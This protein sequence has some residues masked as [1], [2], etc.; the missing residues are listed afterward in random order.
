MGRNPRGG[1]RRR[2]PAA[3]HR[4]RRGSARVDRADQARGAAERWRTRSGSRSRS[5][6]PTRRRRRVCSTVFAAQG[7]DDGDQRT[8]PG[9][10]KVASKHDPTF[11]RRDRG[12]PARRDHGSEARRSTPRDGKTGNLKGRVKPAAA[13]AQMSGKGPSGVF[14]WNM[15]PLMWLTFSIAGHF[16]SGKRAAGTEGEVEGGP[17]AREEAPQAGDQDGQGGAGPRMPP[18]S[19]C[20]SR[21]STRPGC[22]STR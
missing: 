14:A 10:Y 7:Q 3:A 1:R 17:P 4:G 12:G 9:F 18:R 2:G 20:S 22:R 8:R 6:S 5:E 15:A 13:L 16:D 21:S 11:F 19:S